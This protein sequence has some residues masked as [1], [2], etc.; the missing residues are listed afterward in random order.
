MLKAHLDPNRN[1]ASRKHKTIDRSVEW[2]IQKTGLQN[3]NHILDLGCGPGLYCTRFAEKGFAV[4][5]IDYSKRSIQYAKEYAHT[6]KLG[7][8][9]ICED[10][11]TIDYTDAFDLVVLIYCDFGVLSSQDRDLLL[12]KI[13]NALKPAGRFL[14]DVCTPRYHDMAKE[15]K[16]WTFEEKGFWRPVPYLLLTEKIKYP[17][18]SVLLTQYVILDNDK[19]FN[20]FRIWDHAYTEESIS[21][22]LSN[23]GFSD[24]HFC[25]DITGN[26]YSDNSETM[27]VIAKK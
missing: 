4:T 16:T 9:Y 21:G 3:G 27:A 8:E 7:I 17:E 22:V 11:L 19:E 5:G 13:Y 23:V 26:G 1:E 14:F 10:Y 15:E 2:I 20:I 24:M 25:G 18:Q 6:H 12:H